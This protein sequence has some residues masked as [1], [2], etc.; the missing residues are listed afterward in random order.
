MT[1]DQ[2]L[3]AE[4]H[5]REVAEAELRET[6]G[7]LSE[8]TALLERVREWPNQRRVM[9]DAARLEYDIDAF[10]KSYRAP[11]QPVA[12]VSGDKLCPV[13]GWPCQSSP[14]ALAWH[15]RGR[16]VELGP[17]EPT[18]D[19]WGDPTPAHMVKPA[20]P[21]PSADHEDPLFMSPKQLRT[22]LTAAQSDVAE[23]RRNLEL[24]AN[25]ARENAAEFARLKRE[26]DYERRRSDTVHGNCMTL[27]RERDDARSR[28]C[29]PA[30][31]AELK[32]SEKLTVEALESFG[33]GWL[34]WQVWAR[35][36][37][38]R[39]ATR[40]QPAGEERQKES[41]SL[42]CTC[43]SGINAPGSWHKDTCQCHWEEP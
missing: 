2:K 37:L 7:A 18:H 17:A 8:A 24:R 6:A 4:T 20:A 15:V 34:P 29:T 40:E 30:E 25:D 12:A 11:A 26:L 38:A 41:C 31:R 27:V 42:A 21:E 32:A 9:S 19:A 10:L 14:S 3:A 16:S 28:A 23:L 43:G 22:A 1:P 13:S 39:R 35:A 33:N 36:V 5:A